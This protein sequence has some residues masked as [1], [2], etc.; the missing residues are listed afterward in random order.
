MRDENRIEGNIAIH[1]NLLELNRP[2]REATCRRTREHDRGM[3]TET[4]GSCFPMKT[5]HRD[6][7]F[8]I[9]LTDTTSRVI[10]INYE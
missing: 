9:R 1:I 7:R 2:I 6:G 10:V 3:E 8:A 4:V 5:I